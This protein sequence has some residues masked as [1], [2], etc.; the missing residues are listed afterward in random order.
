MTAVGSQRQGRL[1]LPKHRC[2]R[3]QPTV[4]TEMRQRFVFN[5]HDLVG[6]MGRQLVWAGG[7]PTLPSPYSTW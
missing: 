4:G 7:T 5:H 6:A 3:R 1:G 2:Q